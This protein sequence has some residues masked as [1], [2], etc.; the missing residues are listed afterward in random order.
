MPLVMVP[1]LV[2]LDPVTEAFIVVPIKSPASTNGVGNII[3]AL[4]SNN[5]PLIFLAV[6]NF[7]A[8][9]FANCVGVM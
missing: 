6:V 1:T 3:S 8:V 5:T 2:K 4:P 7:F 9:I